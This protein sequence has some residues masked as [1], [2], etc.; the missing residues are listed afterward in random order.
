TRL[1]G[2]FKESKSFES[3]LQA[4][5]VNILGMEIDKNLDKIILDGGNI[6]W[7]GNEVSCGVGV[8]TGFSAG[9]AGFASGAVVACF[10]Q[11]ASNRINASAATGMILT[12]RIVS[13]VF[14]HNNLN[15]CR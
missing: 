10:A 14:I 8:T 15:D 9:A 5:I 6:E 13:P 7:L 1:V 4:Y 3:H 11:P 2:K 12:K